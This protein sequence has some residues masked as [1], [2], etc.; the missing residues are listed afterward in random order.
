MRIAEDPEAPFCIRNV[1]RQQGIFLS[2]HVE[3]QLVHAPHLRRMPLMRSP[4]N[5]LVF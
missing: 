4:A 2:R 3:L 5:E 1:R